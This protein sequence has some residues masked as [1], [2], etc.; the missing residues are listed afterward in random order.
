MKFRSTRGLEKGIASADAIINGISKD[1]GLY[2][3]DEFPLI[4]DKL[5]KNTTIKYEDLAFNV[6]NE[7]F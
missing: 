3:P 2:V 5:K 1:G 7:Y 6:I 4:Y